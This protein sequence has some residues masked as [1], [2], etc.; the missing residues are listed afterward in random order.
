MKSAIR[1]LLGALLAACALLSPQTQADDID[2]YTGGEATTGAQANVLIV[3]D[4]STNWAAASQH[5]ATGK[6]GESELEALSEVLSTLGDSVNVGLLL[7]AGSNGGYVRF[8]VRE[9]NTTNK[10]AFTGMLNTMVA[11]FGGDG[12]NDDKVNSASIVYDHMMNASYRY[13]NGFARFGTTDLPSGSAPDLR[14]YNGNNNSPT[15]QPA[16]PNSLGGYSLASNVATT[17]SPPS[18]ANGGCSKNFII[19]V[20]NGY[21]NST[22]SATDLSDAAGLAGITDS[23]TLSAITAAISGGS[24]KIADEWARFMYNYGVTSTVDD[25]RSTTTPKAKLINRITT[26]TIDVCK[27]AC[28]ADQATLLK[29]MAKVGGGK[30]FK[31]TSKAEIKNAMALIFAE[32]QAVNS[33]FASASLPVSVNTQGTFENQIYVGVFR[34]DGGS[35][36][37]WF[38]NLKEYKI[39]R[40]CDIDRDG[41]VRV[42]STRAL[43]N[44]MIPATLTGNATGPVTGTFSGSIVDTAGVT[45][46]VSGAVS[47]AISGTARGTLAAAFGSSA[48]TTGSPGDDLGSGTVTGTITGTGTGSGTSTFTGTLFATPSLSGTYTATDWRIGEDVPVP[49]CG[50]DASGKIARLPYFSDRN[51]N[52]A[53]DDSGGTGFID[54]QARSHWSSASTFW[55]AAPSSTSGSSDLPDGPEVERGAAAQRLRAT[56]AQTATAPHQDGRKVYTCLGTCLAGAAAADKQLYNSANAVYTTN[57]AVTTALA[58]PS[59]S[60]TVSLVRVGDTVTATSTAAHGFSDGTATIAGATPTDYNGAKTITVTDTTHFTYILNES[61]TTTDTATASKSGGTVTVT[62]I[63]LSGTPPGTPGTT[64]TA[65]VTTGSPHGLAPGNPTTIAGAAQPFLNGVQ[66]VVATPAPDAPHTFTF[67]VTIPGG[68]PTTTLGSTATIKCGGTAPNETAD[69]LSSW[70]SA[71]GRF[72]FPKDGSGNYGTYPN[73]CRNAT[74]GATVTVT[75]AA[76]SK[77]NGSWTVISAGNATVTVGTLAASTAAVSPDAG[78]SKTATAPGS[79]FPISISRAYGSTT[80]TATTA[81]DHAFTTADTITITGAQSQYNGNWVPATVGV[82]TASRSFTFGP[83]TV[84]PTTPPTGTITATVSGATAG[85]DTTNLILWTRG[86]DLWEDEDLNG[87]LTNVRASIHADV[88]HSRPAVVNYGSSIGIVGFYGANDGFLRAIHGGTA[89]VDGEEKWAFIPSEFM[90]YNKLSRLYKNSNLVRYP[91][92]KCDISPTPTARDYFWDGPITVYQSPDG[93]SST[94]PTKT[95][96]FAIMRRG[97]RSM[98]ALDVTDPDTPKFMWRISNTHFNNTALVGAADR[99]AQGNLHPRRCDGDYRSGGADIRRRLRRGAGGQADRQFCHAD[100]GSRR[101]R[102]RGRDRAVDPVP[103]AYHGRPGLQLCR[104][105]HCV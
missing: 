43:V 86:K 70:D 59:G 77:Y 64:V 12:D 28:E 101:V 75:G 15:K 73:G 25:P 29:S 21:P 54:L 103:G 10:T 84:T 30:Y 65:T 98:Y 38:G 50:T 79:S 56:W 16:F 44:G 104:R 27:D 76:D 36:P 19:F 62:S 5:W 93:T 45:T 47:S 66:T 13:F 102:G 1:K 97:G 55:A 42:D 49:D 81:A 33:V 41:G 17:Y 2:L 100:H 53:T 74:A 20:G 78:I 22:G 82:P 61:P 96:L 34:P 91:N 89:S 68:N 87:A 90:N 94:P 51:G 95:W 7:A 69:E 14:D 35:R 83:I 105:H 32:I 48:G 80:A 72:T 39:G 4:N 46:A 57:S 24:P 63:V 3:L 71:T 37:R 23:A 31:S 52:R 26:Y 18:A 8:A 99:Q 58:A 85:P 11:N 92:L 6:Q 67:S 60:A 40:F 9:M 88:L